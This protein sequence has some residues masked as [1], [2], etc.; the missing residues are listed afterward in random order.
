MSSHAVSPIHEL[1]PY[2]ELAYCCRPIEWTAPERLALCSLLHG[3]PRPKAG[4]YRVLELGCA[5]GANLLPLA[6]DRRD[7][8]F[9]GID[10]AATQIQCANENK[11]V[12]GLENVAFLHAD[13]REARRVLDGKFD[14]IIAHGVFSWI[15]DEARDALLEL[16]S[17]TLDEDGLLYLNYNTYPG[18]SMRGL[19]REFLIAQTAGVAGLAERAQQAQRAAQRMAESFEE[20]AP[21]QAAMQR[22]YSALLQNEFRFVCEHDASYVA[23]EYLSPHNRAYWRSDFLQLAGRYGFDYVADADF[24][25]VSGRLPPQIGSTLVSLDLTGRTVEDTVDLLCYRQLHS[26]ILARG[27]LVRRMPDDAEF[28]E[29]VMGSCLVPCADNVDHAWFEHPQTAYRVEAREASMRHALRMLQPSWPAGRQV[30]ALFTGPTIPREDLVLLHSHGLIELRPAQAS[31][32]SRQHV[33][34]VPQFECHGSQ[35]TPH[36]QQVAVET[37]EH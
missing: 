25:Y 19:V 9:T 18:W 4:G 36:H 1:N 23:H 6:H 8:D 22:P 31:N 11:R 16:C 35:V 30:K 17:D 7:A 2:D 27:P 21:E 26:P 3:G 34:R 15:P 37:Q 20:P 29:L 5:N 12:L 33:Q 10:G 13:F 32:D 28:G 14:F 24:N